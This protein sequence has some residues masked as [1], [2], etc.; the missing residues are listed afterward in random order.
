M[1]VMEEFSWCES[2]PDGE[3]KFRWQVKSDGRVSN[4]LM[5]KTSLGRRHK[6]MEE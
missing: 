6:V 1:K 5:E 2:N 4:N 3:D